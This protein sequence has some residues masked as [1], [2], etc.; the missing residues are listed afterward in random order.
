MSLTYLFLRFIYYIEDIEVINMIDAL[1]T[2]AQLI[3]IPAGILSMIISI[4][5]ILD[6]Y[7]KHQKK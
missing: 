3:S 7:R 6:Q 2:L 5:I 1:E 4:L